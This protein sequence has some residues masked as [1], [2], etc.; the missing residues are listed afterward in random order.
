MGLST[1]VPAAPAA[2][3]AP[4]APGDDD[5]P[6]LALH[7]RAAAQLLQSGAVEAAVDFLR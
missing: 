6:P 3:A 2:P 4:T 7:A 1:S 5:V